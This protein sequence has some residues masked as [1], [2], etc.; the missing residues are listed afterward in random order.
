MTS[1]LKTKT[2]RR[3]L[4]GLASALAL[5]AVAVAPA[6]ARPDADAGATAIARH[7]Q[8]PTGEIGSITRSQ[9]SRTRVR[10]TYYPVDDF[11]LAVN[12]KGFRTGGAALAP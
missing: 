8:V 10:K 12:N 6:A 5:A 11:G 2:S 3:T 1:Q 9:P 4:A 7:M